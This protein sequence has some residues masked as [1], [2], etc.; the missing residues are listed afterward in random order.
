MPRLLPRKT[1]NHQIDFKG[2]IADPKT[3]LGEFGLFL[4]AHFV[5]TAFV[6]YIDSSRRRVEDN[7]GWDQKSI[8]EEIFNCCN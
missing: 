8:N 3:R 2:Q 7:A 5:C 6:S 4:G 1:K